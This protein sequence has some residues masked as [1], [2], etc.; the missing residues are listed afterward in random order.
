MLRLV[1]SRPTAALVLTASALVLGV[2]VGLVPARAAVAHAATST[3][4]LAPA[5]AYDA[6]IAE[7][8]DL[9]PLL[10]RPIRN[11]ALYAAGAGGLAPIPFH[12]FRTPGVQLGIAFAWLRDRMGLAG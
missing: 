8:A 5:R 9:G 12:R 11:L 2:A 6:V 7:G 1:R 10:G 4:A 3:N